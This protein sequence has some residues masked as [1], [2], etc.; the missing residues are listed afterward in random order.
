FAT[1]G[2]GDEQV[3]SRFF[4]LLEDESFNLF[5][6]KTN[7]QIAVDYLSKY[8]RDESSKKAPRL[9]R[10]GNDSLKRGAYKLMKALLTSK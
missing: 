10:E 9:F 2:A 4:E 3:T 6:K 8:A 5:F 1:T 7:Q